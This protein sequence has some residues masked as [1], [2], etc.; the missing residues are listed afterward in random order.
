MRLAFVVQRYGLE[1]NGGAE[2][3][4]RQLAERM[5][6][7]MEVEVLTTCAQDHLTWRN[8]YA[9]GQERINNVTVRRFPVDRER[10]MAE[11]RH[12]TDEILGRPR[13]YL[14]EI[15]WMELQGPISSGLLQFLDMRN[16]QYDLFFFFT[17]LYAS[18]FLGLQIVPHKSVLLATAHDD[19]WIRFGIFRP[20]FHL[21]RAFIYNTH[22]ERS[23]I[24]R[25]F[26]NAYIPGLVL[27]NGIDAPH[28]AEV[29]A[30]FAPEVLRSE[31]R[32]D[33]DDDFIIFVGRVDPSKGC[34]QLFEYFIRY[35]SESGSKVRLLL[36][37]K[38]A[39]A[40]PEHPDIISLGFLSDEPYTWMA[41][42]RA[43]VLPSVME[44]LSLVLLESLGL[45]VPVLVNG[46]CAVTRGHC[47]RSNGGLY[48][49]NYDE[50]ASALTLL[51]S[52]PEL[53]RQ[54]GRQGQEYIRANYAWEVV[55]QRFVDWL[56]WV[57]S[58]VPAQ[59]SLTQRERNR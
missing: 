22:E 17:Y 3:H 5:A 43:L 47:Q 13:T 50:F 45:G 23:L 30:S 48:Y 51:L 15:R 6:R 29:A 19:P 28:L 35:K 9:P 16:S 56:T 36:I 10:N 1:V 2:V 24:H 59:W 41:R 57:A 4:C 52:R 21:P 42:A 31:L 53:C 18:T 54:L 33:P 37:G 8:V 55:E 27:G 20:L 49:R 58:W 7:H 46:S 26:K 14:D 40:I 11:F 12:F 38:P 32:V 34:D 39:M 44:S 25:L